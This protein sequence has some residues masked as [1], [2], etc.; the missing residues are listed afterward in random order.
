M[1]QNGKTVLNQ[2]DERNVARR[3][4]GFGQTLP[5]SHLRSL[6]RPGRAIILGATAFGPPPGKSGKS[7]ACVTPGV[8][9]PHPGGALESWNHG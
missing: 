6:Y 9:Q 2:Y 8:M 4:A 3:F 7:M 1:T 5:Q